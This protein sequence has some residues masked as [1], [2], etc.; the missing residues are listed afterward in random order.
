MNERIEIVDETEISIRR[1]QN[2][3]ITRVQ[4]IGDRLEI[5]GKAWDADAGRALRDALACLGDTGS[6]AALADTSAAAFRGK[7]MR[8]NKNNEIVEVLSVD[9]TTPLVRY[10]GG[11]HW[12]LIAGEQSLL[13]LAPEPPKKKYRVFTPVEAAEHIG[14][15]YKR[16]DGNSIMFIDS[17]KRDGIFN[18]MGGWWDFRSLIDEAIWA[19][20]NEPCGTPLDA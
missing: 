17:V 9:R 13:P 8:F 3:W 5:D 7:L 18:A 6:F 11:C 12:Y 20:T 19:D 16:I 10:P 4:L 1:F 14:R 2:G 15:G